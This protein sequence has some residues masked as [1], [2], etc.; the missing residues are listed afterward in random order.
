MWSILTILKG[1]QITNC[2]NKFRHSLWVV[3]VAIEAFAV[4][5]LRL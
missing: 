3:G 1:L 4:D 5:K 2:E